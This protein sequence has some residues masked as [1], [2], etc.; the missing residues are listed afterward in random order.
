MLRSQLAFLSMVG[1][2]RFRPDKS[3][4]TRAAA[5]PMPAAAPPFTI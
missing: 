4:M 1:P 3:A 5:G 2:A